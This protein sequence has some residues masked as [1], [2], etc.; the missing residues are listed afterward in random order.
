[1]IEGVD[2]E[3]EGVVEEEVV[4]EE[5]GVAVAVEAVVKI[6]I[7][8]I[9]RR[10][11][12]EEEEAV[13]GEV[14]GIKEHRCQFNTKEVVGTNNSSNFNLGGISSNLARTPVG[15]VRMIPIVVMAVKVVAAAEEGVVGVVVEEEEDINK[16]FPFQF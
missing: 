9:I 8:A 12:V 5:A 2:E 4:V 16:L 10:L 15:V 1:M 13:A 14:A 3:A 6:T 7:K 11:V